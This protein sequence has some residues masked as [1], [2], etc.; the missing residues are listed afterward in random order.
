MSR[1]VA[2]EHARTPRQLM[3]SE[4]RFHASQHVGGQERQRRR[5]REHDEQELATEGRWGVPDRVQDDV[6]DR[7]DR[8]HARDVTTSRVACIGHAGERSKTNCERRR[9]V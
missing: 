6:C 2:H 5:P 3:R 9:G 8:T 4:R 7:R 1:A